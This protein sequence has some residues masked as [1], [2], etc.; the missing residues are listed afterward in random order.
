MRATAS[1]A[2]AGIEMQAG[3]RTTSQQEM[4]NEVQVPDRQC[5]C[6]SSLAIYADDASVDQQHW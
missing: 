3:M 4:T 1:L 5:V 2:V 6:R